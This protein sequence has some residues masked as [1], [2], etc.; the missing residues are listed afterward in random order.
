MSEKIRIAAHAKANLFLRILSR[1]STGYHN[2]E[3]AFCLLELADQITVSRTQGT[4][5]TLSVQ[6]AD[7][8]PEKENLAY[9][10][11]STVLESIRNPFAVHIELEK[12]IPI[13][14]GLGGASSDA[15]ATLHAVNKLAGEPVPRH[16]LLQL[17]PRLGADVAFFAS[18]C[19]L[20]VGWGRG[21]RLFRIPPPKASPVLIAVPNFG[22]ST[23]AAYQL[24]DS[25]HDDLRRGAMVLDEDAFRTWGGIGRL[26][27]ND[28]ETP[29]FGKHPE[30]RELFE[31]V[32]ETRPLLV[33]MTGSGSGVFAVYKSEEE[34]DAASANIG[35]QGKALIK[36]STRNTPAPGPE[37]VFG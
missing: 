1:E 8:G 29:V 9:R 22:V 33:R 16:E 20:A 17:A 6:G 27:G 24:V 14:S 37:P 34:R 2:L 23:V 30:L 4:G 3:T 32:A 31:R 7:T 12:H 18:G 21:E 5:V 26:G 35:S 10:A 25:A 15:A 11:A 36:T 19:P 28:F 13:Q